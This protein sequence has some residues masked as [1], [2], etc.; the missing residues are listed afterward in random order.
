MSRMTNTATAS[1]MLNLTDIVASTLAERTWRPSSPRRER[2]PF[3]CRQREAG[4]R[5][6]TA[7][8]MWLDAGGQNPA[9]TPRAKRRPIYP[10]TSV[11]SPQSLCPQFSVLKP[12]VLGSPW[13]LPFRLRRVASPAAARLALTA[14]VYSCSNPPTHALR[15]RSRRYSS[16]LGSNV[17]QLHP[18]THVASAAL[19]W[20]ST[21]NSAVDATSG[22]TTDALSL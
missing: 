16:D 5:S 14:G 22:Y 18:S 20:V 8:S 10:G 11:F 6:K 4:G 15:R 7:P 9:S 2:G 21:P 12:S 17:I 13:R 1:R 3:G 19:E